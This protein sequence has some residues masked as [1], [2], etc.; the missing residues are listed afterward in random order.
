MNIS[1]LCLTL[2]V[3]DSVRLIASTTVTIGIVQ[4]V[5]LTLFQSTTTII[6]G[7]CETCLCTLIS[8]LSL[9]S[10]NCFKSNL[11]CEMHRMSD[12]NKPFELVPFVLGVYYFTSLPTLRPDNPTTYSPSE[13]T[14]A[15]TSKLVFFILD[16]A[17]KHTARFPT[18]CLTY[19]WRLV[20]T[21]S[22]AEHDY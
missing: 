4:N 21:H 1:L 6:N 20:F 12:R 22:D 19:S 5:S 2:V 14:T 10:F 16:A 15:P 11:T 9:F 8:D 17:P 18:K 13:L 3:C 7:T